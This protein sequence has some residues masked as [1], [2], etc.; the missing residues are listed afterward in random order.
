MRLS[1]CL[2]CFVM[3]YLLKAFWS[4]FEY[5]DDW[6]SAIALCADV[7]SFDVSFAYSAPPTSLLCSLQTV[8]SVDKNYQSS[9][10]LQHEFRSLDLFSASM[11]RATDYEWL[12]SIGL[13]LESAHWWPVILV[14]NHCLCKSYAI[15]FWSL[16]CDIQLYFF[17]YNCSFTILLLF[18]SFTEQY[19]EMNKKQCREALDI[20]KK[21][22]LRMEKVSTFLRVAEVS[23]QALDFLGNLKA[24]TSFVVHF[25][26]CRVDIGISFL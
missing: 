11:L 8:V 5:N 6:F 7:C 18:I 16:C 15:H 25:F 10:D 24:W 14:M 13:V 19:F 17:V 2:V 12:G 26:S 23:L 3:W 22:V 20:Y 21:F 9:S 4:S 1:V